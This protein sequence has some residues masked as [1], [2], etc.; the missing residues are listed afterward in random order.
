MRILNRKR[1]R[2]IFEYLRN[3]ITKKYLKKICRKHIKER[4]QLVVYSFD[5]ISQTIFID[6]RFEDSELDLVE[7][8]FKKI[9]K[10]NVVLDIGANIGNHT[11]AFSKYAKKVYA[12]EPNKKV[13]EV[14]NLN[15]KHFKNV[16]IFNYG[17]SNKKQSIVAN[18]PKLNCGAGSVLDEAKAK[19]KN[20]FMNMSF[21]LVALDKL[22]KI[23]SHKI[24][25][26][27]IDVE[28]HELEAL[29]GMQQILKNHK[30]IVLFEQNR[31]IFNGTSDVINFL[32]SVGY[33]NL[34]EL[35]K[36]DDWILKRFIP[37]LFKSLFEI[38]EV[39]LIGIPSDKLEL[40][41]IKCLTKSSYDMLI[42]TNSELN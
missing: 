39:L 7:N 23:Q 35:K 37:K 25:L 8:K 24:G 3:K 5:F 16:E 4:N 13:F 19:N 32:R 2:N 22:K 33:D 6:G 27:K 10:D 9:L 17:A 34:Y 1:N 12:F 14:L 29:K 41:S 15:T 11:I 36:A 40:K 42:M 38:I 26:V 30:P 18:I 20:N 21:N 28:G 31:G